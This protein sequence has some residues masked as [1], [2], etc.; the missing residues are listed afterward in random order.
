MYAAGHCVACG[1]PVCERHGRLAASHEALFR[2]RGEVFACETCRDQATASEFED[3]R[4]SIEQNKRRIVRLIDRIARTEPVGLVDIGVHSGPATSKGGLLPFT[5][6][7]VEA[8]ECPDAHRNCRK[9]DAPEPSSY[10]SRQWY[11]RRGYLL[12]S[13]SYTEGGAYGRE[14]DATGWVCLTEDGSAIFH[15]RGTIV[16][17]DYSV[18]EYLVR[19]GGIDQTRA[20]MLI[21]S[22]ESV[23][24]GKPNHRRR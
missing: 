19:F 9:V 13:F 4:P 24:S 16:D 10:G 3:A 17:N 5:K 12:Q 18:D 2:Q 15:E 22:L 21:E 20:L 6:A 7:R 11:A 23:A 8:P 14:Y 1:R